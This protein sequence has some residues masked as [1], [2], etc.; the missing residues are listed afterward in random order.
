ML[1]TFVPND[2]F[3]AGQDLS[4]DGIVPDI[5]DSNDFAAIRRDRNSV[6]VCTGANACGK[7]CKI[8]GRL[9]R[10]M[11]LMCLPQSVYLKQVA[12][13]QFMAQVGWYIFPLL[14]YELKYCTLTATAA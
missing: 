11:V 5:G 10:R 13:I 9:N 7:V 2:A 12:L 8:A 14:C 6:V 1:D 4:P 3:I